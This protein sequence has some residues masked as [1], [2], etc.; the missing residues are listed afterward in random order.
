MTTAA[1]DEHTLSRVLNLPT[2]KDQEF[3]NQVVSALQR[4]DRALLPPAASHPLSG[5]IVQGP[6][7]VPKLLELAESADPRKSA[8]AL[9]A[10]AHVLL[11]NRIAA[12]AAKRLHALMKTQKNPDKAALIAKVL[13]IGGDEAL[14][15]DQLRLLAD[16]DPGLVATAARLLGLGHY[17]P[18]VPVLRALVSPDRMYESR[19]VIWALGEIGDVSAT[20]E[21]E[22]AL[23]SGFR[24]VDAI[25]ALGKLGQ[26]TTIP[27][28][29][30]MI[31][32]G[33]PEQRDAAYRAL[34]MILDENRDLA[35]VLGTARND[36]VGLIV[37][38]LEDDKVDLSGSTRFHMLLC[39]ARLEEKLDQARVR[40]Y[41]RIDLHEKEAGGMATFF[42]SRGDAKKGPTK[43]TQK[44][45][46]AEA[47][48][49]SSFF[50]KR[51]TKK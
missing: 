9:D 28:L 27:R 5:L 45:T 39:L 43:K 15:R 21:L 10:L 12:P 29:T 37:G 14:L 1:F 36:L 3:A 30:P 46:P 4:I 31:L 50:M 34:A 48:A 22:L 33:L 35:D 51:G 13:A 24:S 42:A 18:A 32:S 16:E 7:R 11:T 40:K 20:R 38:Q 8:D 47:D 2:G 17:S 49:M 41:L 6:E 23:A 25:I 26:I 44:D 19:M